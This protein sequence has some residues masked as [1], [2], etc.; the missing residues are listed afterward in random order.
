MLPSHAL[1]DGFSL[2]LEE[3]LGGPRVRYGP[4]PLEPFA[5][6]CRNTLRFA[7]WLAE[8]EAGRAVSA[9]DEVQAIG[10]M[11][12]VGVVSSSLPNPV[13][14]E[15]GRRV[16]DRWKALGVLSVETETAEIARC[17]A[18]Y[19][20]AL[21][22][23]DHAIR[24]QYCGYME[25]WC[26]LVALRS[27]DYWTQ[28]LHHLYMPLFLDQYDKRGFNPFQLFVTLTDGDIGS[29]DLW[30]SWALEPWEGHNHLARL[31]KKVDSFRPGGTRAFVRAL[32]A[33]RV[34]DTAPKKFPALF[35]DWGIS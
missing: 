29:V 26:R 14:T 16:L 30:R 21:R 4:H 35:T 31:L 7:P 5:T 33:C 24:Q 27:A 12:N 28:D 19:R 9:A 10:D 23:G 8:V 17:A 32:E 1:R 2:W 20:T 34:V 22:F 13:A 11:R 18:L 3:V 6:S 15:M 25:S